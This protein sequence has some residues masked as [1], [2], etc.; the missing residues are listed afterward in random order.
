MKRFFTLLI[1][2]IAIVGTVGA[3][4]TPVTVYYAV[5]ANTVGTYTVM[6]NANIGDNNTWRQYDMSNTGKTYQGRDIYSGTIYV[7]YGGVDA[8]QFQLYEGTTWKSEQKPY[9]TYTA[10][11]TFSGK[12]YVHNTGWVD[13]TTDPTITIHFKNPDNWSPIQAY[14]WNDYKTNGSY[15]STAVI[16]QNT[17]NSDYYDFAY[18]QYYN[19]VIFNNNGGTEGNQTVN[20]SIDRSATEYWVTCD[21]TYSDNKRNAS[22]STS[23]PTGFNYTRSVTS[24]NFGTICLPYAAEVSGATVFK[25]V[26]TVGSGDAITGINLESVDVLEAGKAY[27][28]KAT[29]SELTAT[30]SGTYTAASAGYGMMGNLSSTPA[31]VDN[32]NYI[33]FGN[34]IHKVNGATVTVGQYRGYITL[35]GIVEASARGVNFI[36]FEDE[37]ATGIDLNVND[38]L[39]S[40]ATM[41]NLAGQRVSENYKGIVVK[42]GKKFINK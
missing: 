24:G 18:D 17:L 28:F 16:S 14:A 19:Y 31:T 38:N 25:I 7:K 2:L 5:P 10:S 1:G 34:K 41:Y 12:M 23:I 32:G 26:S 21:G 6:V 15:G 13:Y 30:L 35:D 42:N 20:I 3:D 11:T 9:S 27:I 37:Q 40:D 39:N 33:I 36:G 8:L 22:A 29:S 4:D